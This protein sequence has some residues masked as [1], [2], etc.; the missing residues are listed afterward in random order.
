[1]GDY[2]TTQDD[3]K[4]T[5]HSVNVLRQLIKVIVEVGDE[6]EIKE[7]H[8]DDLQF[9]KKYHSKDKSDLSPEE[10]AELERLEREEKEDAEARREENKV[11]RDRNRKGPWADAP[12]SLHDMGAALGPNASFHLSAPDKAAMVLQREKSRTGQWPPHCLS[13]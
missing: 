9:K 7:Y 1:M 11:S 3:L 8:V 5:V 12:A 4:G 6:K 10:Q 2:V 13:S